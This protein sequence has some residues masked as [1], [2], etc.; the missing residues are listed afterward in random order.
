MT[1]AYF[2]MTVTVGVMGGFH[3]K[4]QQRGVRDAAGESADRGRK[5]DRLFDGLECSH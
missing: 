5:G 1:R 3:R 4:V 2:G